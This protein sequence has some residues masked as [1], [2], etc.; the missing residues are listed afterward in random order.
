MPDTAPGGGGFAAALKDGD[1]PRL[2]AA[3][4]ADLHCHSILGAG[5][6]GIRAWAGTDIADPPARMASFDEMRAYTRAELYPFIRNR[7]G[8]EHTAEQALGE[9][10]ADGVRVLEMSLDVDFSR[11][12]RTGIPGYLDFIIGLCGRTRSLI[13][14]RP[15]IGVSKNRDPSLQVRLAR[16][17]VESGVFRSIDLYGNEDAQEPEAYSE[18]FRGAARRG[19]KLKAHVGEFGDAALV[20]RTLRV[21]GLNEVQHGVS[22]AGSPRLM[23]ILRAER[24]RLNVCPG[25]N[26]ALSVARDL[27]THPI[28]IL[29]RAGVR[30]S[31]GSDD[32]MVFGKSVTEEYLGLYQAGTLEAEELDAIRADSLMD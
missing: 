21:L 24:I 8:F 1:L 20:E 23:Q 15:E 22:A 9:A 18:L 17:C 27:A 32:K 7:A 10:A 14:F 19:L 29:A 3:A 30:V 16:E 12:Y 4:K 5:L 28:R 26:I 6:P 2:R 25:S 11:F 13:D 31:V